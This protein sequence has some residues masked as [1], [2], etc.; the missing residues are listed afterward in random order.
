MQCVNECVFPQRRIFF[1]LPNTTLT[2]SRY[3]HLFLSLS[4]FVYI[5]I[6]FRV[7]RI[8]NN[9]KSRFGLKKMA[10]T[11][12]SS[13]SPSK[14]NRSTSPKRSNNTATIQRDEGG[15]RMKQQQIDAKKKPSSDG[16]N[17]IISIEDEVAQGAK[18]ILDDKGLRKVPPYYFT[19]L[20]FCK[21]RWRDRK[22]LDIFT[23]EFRD[24]EESYYRKAIQTGKVY[25]NNKV[26][27]LDTVVRNGELIKHRTHKHEPPVPAK[28]VRIVHQDEELVVIDKP[29]GI[30]V[31]PT[32]RYRFNTVVM[33]LKH[34]QNLL[35]HPCNRLDKLTSGLMFLAKTSKGAGK[36]SEQLRGREVKKEYIARVIGEFPFGEEIT[37]EEPVI[38][39][40]PKVALNRVDRENGKE[41]KTVFKRISYDGET[42]IVKCKPYTGRTHQIRVH[43]QHLGYPIANDPIYSNLDVWGPELGANG[44]GDTE[45]I[46]NKL[47]EI[48]KSQVA[49]SWYYPTSSD[50]N[51]QQGEH[52][53]GEQCEVC[54]TDLY[55]DPGPNDMGLWL[56]ALKYYSDD[57]SWSYETEFP[58]WALESYNPFMEM[59][60]EEAN[61][62]PPTETAFCVGAVLVKDG[63]VL[64]TGYTG[65]LPGNTHAE[66]SAME[67]YF[68]N[69][70]T[71]KLPEGT[72]V[73]TSME[74]CSERLSG[75]LPCAD[76]ILNQKQNVSTVFVGVLEPDTFVQKNIGKA[77]LVDNGIEYIHIPGFSERAL[78]IA[79][80]GHKS[81]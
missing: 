47:Y 31:H 51:H 41:A 15:F 25:V 52:L 14:R 59:A 63:K 32:G 78:K 1:N 67:K 8:V 24:K 39:V 54:E 68:Q 23:S 58:D 42:S 9:Y 48:G 19:Y 30:P 81:E 28:E 43:L 17:K 5:F 49:Q 34:E 69:N 36:M 6:I 27:D 38:T 50:S 3:T 26:A 2:H 33:V 70:N 12:N 73:Y 66:Q 64:E 77:K 45:A 20:T 11:E 37:C 10:A 13:S 21:L 72:V 76:R 7:L 53:T 57:G 35:V 18:Y 62:S 29:S 16:H 44:S 74:P 60:L 79:K 40:A 46:V 55:T 75:N 22:L 4:L 56:H 80:K 71:D 65:E 61:K